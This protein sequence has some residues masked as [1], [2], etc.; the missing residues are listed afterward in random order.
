MIG[1]RGQ[2]RAV[3]LGAACAPGPARARV[4]ATMAENISLVRDGPIATVTLNR[5]DRRNS[6][7]DPLLTELGAAFA[8]LRD[9]ADTRVV[10]LTGAPPVFSSG[11]D[12]GFRSGMSPEERREAFRRRQSQF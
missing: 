8:E 2:E 5:P 12:A 10:I 1:Q 3:P 7:S 6:L 4:R 11:A 9:D